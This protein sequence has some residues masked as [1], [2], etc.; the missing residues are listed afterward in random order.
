M[1]VSFQ[2]LQKLKVKMSAA[3]QIASD[4]FRS[5]N[6]DPKWRPLK[7]SQAIED[8]KAR[9]G[10]LDDLKGSSEFYRRWATQPN[11][12][13]YAKKEWTEPQ[14]QIHLSGLADLTSAVDQ[15]HKEATDLQLRAL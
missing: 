3:L 6:N 8:L 4:I 9:V 7:G 2:N 1:N 10:E 12:Q 13:K 11:F 15:V 5:L 14:L